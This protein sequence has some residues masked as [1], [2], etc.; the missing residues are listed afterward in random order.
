GTLHN[1]W[2]FHNQPEVSPKLK[3]EGKHDACYLPRSCRFTGDIRIHEIAYAGDELWA[4]NTRFSC[5]CTFDNHHS[6][7]PRWKPA[8][9]SK[10]AAEDR[11]HMNGFAV[12]DG[13]VKHLTALGL[14]DTAGGWRDNKRN[15]GVLM[16]I[17]S[18]EVLVRGLSMPHSPRWHDGKLWILESGYGALGTVDLQTGKVEHVCTLPGFTRGLDFCGPY[19]FVGLSQVRESSVFSGLPIVESGQ[20]REC[21]VHVVDL[22]I[23]KSIAFLRFD[24][25]VQE[26]FAVQV[27][28]NQRWP[29]VVHDD[30]E[31]LNGTFILPP[32]TFEPVA[33]RKLAA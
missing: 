25:G 2:E 30:A 5:L 10:L 19:A 32:G 31:V 20:E 7:V 3:P 22:R 24:G 23:G 12:K 26:I 9:I 18:G 11:C 1:V 28:P 16:E 8:F 21:G 27:L 15:G 6:F 33:A 4:V 14:T 13:A 17:P 29:D